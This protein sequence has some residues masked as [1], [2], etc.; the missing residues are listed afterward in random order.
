MAVE[1]T[2][3]RRVAQLPKDQTTFTARYSLE[4]TMELPQIARDQTSI[5]LIMELFSRGKMWRND[6]H[7]WRL[8]ALG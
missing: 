3:L 2:A 1:R 7:R 5:K 4:V 6:T 8:R